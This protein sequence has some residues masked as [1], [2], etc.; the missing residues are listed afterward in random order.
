MKN[1]T[2]INGREIAGRM[3]A[4]T[5]ENRK[6]SIAGEKSVT[7]RVI[8]PQ[9]PNDVGKI[10]GPEMYNPIAVDKSGDEYPGKEIYG[11]YDDSGEWGTRCPYKPGEIRVMTE[12][13]FKID[14]YCGYQDDKYKTFDYPLVINNQTHEL[15]KWRWKID[16]LQSRFML[17]E[18]GRFL[19]RIT[20]VS[21]ER[22]QDISPYDIQ[23]EGLNDN[24]INPIF[25]AANLQNKFIDL[26]N[27]INEKRGYGWS[28]NP[29]VWIIDFER[30]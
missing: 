3:P 16:V 25:R 10:Y 18:A 24:A 29:W 9:P 12:P 2:I 17:M 30:M 20:E 1:K 14:D 5:A 26:W 15:L 22:V 19:Y 4:F 13:L 28:V 7:R 11:I 8:I 21:A 6:K 23:K 27:S